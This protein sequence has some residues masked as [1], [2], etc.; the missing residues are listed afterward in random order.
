MRKELSIAKQIALQAGDIMLHYFD[1]GQ[2]REFK[3]DGTPVTIADTQVNRMVIE[4]LAQAFPTDGVVGEEESTAEYGLGRRWI[5]DPIDGTLSYTWGLPASMFS[6]ALA[7]D[8]VPMIGVAYDPFL[9]RLYWAVRGKGSYCNNQ[10]LH[11]SNT[12]ITDGIVGIEPKLASIYDHAPYITKLLAHNKQPAIF[13]GAVFRGCLVARGKLVGY[14]DPN[15]RPHDIAATYLIIEEA[16]G[17]VTDITG[18]SLDFS[19]PFKGA[20]LSNGVAHE[21]L[22]DL[23]R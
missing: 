5:C 19:R 6:L 9:K 15:V 18:K 10:S 7:I 14:P 17:K 13:S 20:V 16:G 22:L 11:V 21:Q 1:G 4:E 12:N 23:F 8:G 3:E 2:Q